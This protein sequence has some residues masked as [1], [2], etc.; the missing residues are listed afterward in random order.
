MRRLAEEKGQVLAIVLV[1]FMIVSVLVPLMIT[2]SQREAHWTNKQARST[3][4]FHMAEAGIEKGYLA[5]SLSTGN[6]TNLQNGVLMTNYQFDRKFEDLGTGGAYT[7]SITSGPLTQQATVISIGRDSL[8]REV[9]A[10]QAVY[11]NATMGDIAIMGVAG[12][13]VSGNNLTVEW[14]GIVSPNA[15]TPN[16][17]NHPS[18]YSADNITGLDTN[19]STLPNC[20]QPNCWF[21]H[22]YYKGLPPQP[23]IDF[24][25]YKSSAQAS[26]TSSC[27]LTFYTSGNHSGT[28]SST[29]GKPFY[30]EGNWS[31][32]DGPVVGSLIVL[33]NMTTPNGA[34]HGQAVAAP[35]PQTA[36]KQYCNDWAFYLTTYGDAAAAAAY[37]SQCPGIYSD[38]LSAASI[39]YNISPVVNGMLYVGGNFTGPNGGGNT[40]IAYGILVVKG[41]V[42]LNSNSNVTYYYSKT[43]A[44]S[45][46]TTQIVLSRA[47]WRDQIRPW[48]S[49]L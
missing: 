5:I 6:W 38:Y 44:Q 27:G 31:N 12:V 18:Y 43:A 33:G 25:F 10:I 40:T 39:T 7:I 47:S 36:W 4:A 41:T 28:C 19:G 45:L 1:V 30:V 20:D 3:T 46:Q 21:W 34:M 35:M 11:A 13:D 15:I 17:E 24:T 8:S 26:G 2:Y 37:P 14:G 48:P 23:L 16:G 42:Y 22:S 9:R 29:D 32:F 49:G